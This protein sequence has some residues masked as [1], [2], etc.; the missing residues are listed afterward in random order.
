MDAALQLEISMD[1][2]QGKMSGVIPD[3][4]GAHSFPPLYNGDRVFTATGDLT[5]KHGTY[6]TSHNRFHRRNRSDPY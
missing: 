5:R 3:Y 4:T 1:N 6:K 2:K